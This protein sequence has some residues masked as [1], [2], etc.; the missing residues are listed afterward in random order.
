MIQTLI[1]LFLFLFT[2]IFCSITVMLLFNHFNK[3]DYVSRWEALLFG[4]GIGPPV[5]TLMLYYLLLLLPGMHQWF[6]LFIICFTFIVIFYWY[7][8]REI[9]LLLPVG[10]R[11]IMI[12]WH[13]DASISLKGQHAWEGWRRI[14]SE[15]SVKPKFY[16]EGMQFNHWLF[17]LFILMFVW[18]WMRFTLKYPLVEHDALEYAVQGMIF[19]K[20]LNIEYVTHRFDTATNFYY[21]G[22]HGFSFPLLSTWQWLFNLPLGFKTDFFFRLQSGYYFALIFLQVYLSARR[23]MK[24]QA[25]YSLLSLVIVYWYYDMLFDYHIDSYRSYLFFFA[26]LCIFILLKSANRAMVVFTALTCG[27]AAF[28]HSTA[29]LALAFCMPVILLYYPG[30]ILKRVGVL[31]MFFVLVVFFGAGHYILDTLFGTGWVFGLKE[32]Y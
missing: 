3:S 22:L 25:I 12:R 10:P 6:Y 20:N 32:T 8:V 9:R 27:L 23:F 31:I 13:L 7:A 16:T 26:V 4:L 2:N 17:L 18:L 28:A 24:K 29:A 15:F 1:A 14:F 30:K 21:V 5:V 11:T 19:A